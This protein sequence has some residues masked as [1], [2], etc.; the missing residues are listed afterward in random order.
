M[1]TMKPVFFDSS[2]LMALAEHPTTW[3]GDLLEELGSYVPVLLDC[4]ER[5]L[6]MIGEGGWRRRGLARVALQMSS[7]FERKR[8]GGADPDSELVSAV[9]S[10]GGSVATTDGELLAALRAAGVGAVTLS[11]GRVSVR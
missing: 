7:G 5:E 3:E 11:K 1:R 9:L 2:F 10:T 4:V 8:S 6:L